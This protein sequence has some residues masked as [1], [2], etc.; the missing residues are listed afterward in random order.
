MA[1][2]S[3]KFKY[4]GGGDQITGWMGMPERFERSIEANPQRAWGMGQRV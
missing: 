3:Q 2:F 4:F 1:L